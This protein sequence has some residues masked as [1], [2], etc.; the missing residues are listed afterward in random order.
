MV[1]TAISVLACARHVLGQ[2]PDNA[3]R[4]FEDFKVQYGRT[5][6]EAEEPRNF[7]IFKAHLAEAAQLQQVS[8]R[9][10]FGVTKF[11]DF[12]LEKFSVLLG[13]RRGKHE[14]R[15]SPASLFS[16]D[17]V[18]NASRSIDWRQ[19]G[20]VTDVKDQGHCGSCWAFSTI[21][22][23]EGQ[24]FLAT[25]KLTA[26]SE[27]QMVSCDYED[28]GCNGGLMS[29]AFTFL[30]EELGGRVVTQEYYPYEAAKGSP[31]ACG[32]VKGMSPICHATSS[33]VTDGWCSSICLRSQ[34][35]AET[36]TP[37]CS[38]A[39]SPPMQHVGAV[40]S[41][42]VTLPHDEDQMATWL[43]QHGPM[44]IAVFGSTWKSYQGGIMDVAACPDIG[45]NHGVVLVGYDL[46]QKYWL[47]KN[48]WGKD[49]GEGGYIRI[50]R[51]TN[52][53]S[54]NNDPG[55]ATIATSPL[56]VV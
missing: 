30:Q 46:D 25:G 34:M 32:G 44:A 56:A 7:E 24:N 47:I 36:C 43:A 4:L 55:S 18:A 16:R 51:G 39:D 38:C 53:C 35:R 6:A 52:A 41:G 50:E 28:S 45:P 10:S 20:A 42:Y 1:K 12:T 8:P 37:T 5:Y 23:I 29:Y 31:G 19:K 21:G 22:N 3:A 15:D 17:E 13:Y 14:K 40:I 11:A 48:S 33:S 54:I 2:D 9:A 27:E 26:L 49:F